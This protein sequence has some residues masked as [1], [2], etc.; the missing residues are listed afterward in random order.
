VVAEIR[1]VESLSFSPLDAGGNRLGGSS[2]PYSATSPAYVGITLKVLDVS[3][4][5]GSAQPS[6]HV[7][8]VRNYITVQDGVDLLNN[9]L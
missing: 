9:S 1:N 6:H 8:G 4:L 7:P 2:A 5:D 3:Q